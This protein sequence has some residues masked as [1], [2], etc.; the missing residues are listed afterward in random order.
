M[1]NFNQKDLINAL[2]KSAGFRP[3]SAEEAVRAIFS[4][5][6]E[7]TEAGRTVRIPGFGQ[8]RMKDRAARTAR[9]PQTGE[10]IEVP[11]KRVLTFKP[12]KTAAA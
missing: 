6:R 11:A 9:N 10:P 1:S 2:R 3:E 5:I 7:E 8:F 12:S 4:I